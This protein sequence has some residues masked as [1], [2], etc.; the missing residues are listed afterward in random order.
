MNSPDIAANDF[1]LLA[2]TRFPVYTRTLIYVIFLSLFYT[3]PI[4]A[5]IYRWVDSNGKVHFGD[6][7]PPDEVKKEL[8]LP[9]KPANQNQHNQDSD[10][11]M[12][13]KRLLDRFQEDRQNRRAAAIKKA[14][15]KKERER[16][17]ALA[18]DRLRIY[19]EAGSLY[20]LTQDGKRQVLS[21]E[22][23]DKVTREARL[24]VSRW[25]RI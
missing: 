23:R 4:S 13:R 10:R 11:A 3:S 8:N 24:A 22:E 21:F 16:N 7:P 17:C 9:Q 25:C 6:R 1:T 19:T 5:G 14:D 15:E 18:K 2:I 12:Q 20:N